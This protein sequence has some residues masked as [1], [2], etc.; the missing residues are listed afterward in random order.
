MDLRSR[1]DLLLEKGLIIEQQ[2]LKREELKNSVVS[3]NLVRRSISM[4][5]KWSQKASRIYISINCN[6]ELLKHPL[7]ALPTIASPKKFKPM[8]WATNTNLIKLRMI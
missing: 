2:T 4:S 6:Q 3:S 1:K 5:S 8:I 7:S